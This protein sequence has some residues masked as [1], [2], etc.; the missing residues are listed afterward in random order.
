MSIDFRCPVCDWKF[1]PTQKS[2]CPSCHTASDEAIK[3]SD[4]NMAAKAAEVKAAPVKNIESPVQTPAT[5]VS[6]PVA[7]NDLIQAIDRQI[8]ASNRTTF[9]VRSMVSYVVITVISGLVG[10]LLIAL[11]FA[12][13]APMFMVLGGLA[14]VGGTIGALVTLIREWALSSVPRN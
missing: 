2:K 5:R 6:S 9:A 14:F 10:A 11:G 13:Q 8:E 4:E 12:F 3:R 1:D 7:N